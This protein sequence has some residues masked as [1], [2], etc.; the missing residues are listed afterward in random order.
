MDE[1]ELIRS[2]LAP[3]VSTPGADGLEDDVAEL[4]VSGRIAA[5]ADTIVEGVHFLADDPIS[6]IA[7][8]LVRVNVSD[9]IA[10][11][12]APSECL[13]SLVWPRQRAASEVEV[14]AAS[15]KSDLDL[16]NCR[17][18]GGDTTSTDGPLV[19]SLTMLGS[20]SSRGP[21]R[22]S[23]ASAGED[24]WVSGTIGDGWLGL[25]A[26]REELVG[27]D[28]EDA[29]WL[30]ESYRV[31]RV[32]Q[33]ELASLIGET[34]G[35]SVDV[36]DGLASDALHVARSSGL[37]IVIEGS[38]VPLSG[39]ARRALERCE[40]V[41]LEHLLAGGD[42]YQVLFSAAA[43]RR[44]EIERFSSEAGVVLTRIGRCEAGEGVSLIGLDGKPLRHPSGWRHQIGS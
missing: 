38:A 7:A 6:S 15:L 3:L 30:A 24:V 4:R 32:Q 18:V 14:F 29:A 33:M 40:G 26:A 16:W 25:K 28:A 36:S 2:Y 20:C 43:D 44:P 42:D 31:P 19:L 12:A 39:P 41:S 13:L 9:L 35:G 1:F 5:T 34:A 22:R 21:V 27:I 37:K 17:L 23:G 10:K 11:G 8:K